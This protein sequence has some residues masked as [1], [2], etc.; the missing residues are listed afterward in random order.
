MSSFLIVH[1]NL[2]LYPCENRTHTHVRFAI[3]AIAPPSPGDCI[4]RCTNVSGKNAAARL[5]SQ[6][7]NGQCGRITVYRCF[8]YARVRLC[9]CACVHTRASAKFQKREKR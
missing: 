5:N 9:V 6:K 3:V 7:F 2:C 8:V 1:V 4:P